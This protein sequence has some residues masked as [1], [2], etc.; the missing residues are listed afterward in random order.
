MFVDIYAIDMIVPYSICYWRE[1]LLTYFKGFQSLNAF[2][3]N[4]HVPYSICYL[5]LLLLQYVS[6]TKIFCSWNT[7][8]DVFCLFSF[9]F[10]CVNLIGMLTSTINL[11]NNF[12]RLMTTYHLWKSRECAN[13]I[14][15]ALMLVGY[16]FC[17]IFI[18]FDYVPKTPYRFSEIDSG[19]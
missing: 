16:I 5:Y 1:Y 9:T 10:L 4:I 14:L 19:V 3:I 18:Q 7:V 12:C 2:L 15:R 17:L 6:L 8:F 13:S 11:F